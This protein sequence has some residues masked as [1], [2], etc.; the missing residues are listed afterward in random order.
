[1]IIRKM[2]LGDAS[3]IAE[4]ERLCFSDPWSEKSI[5]SEAEN[6]LSY[7]LVAEL[8]GKVVGYVGSQTVLDAA[9]MMNLAVSPDYRRQ[10]IGQALVNALVDHLKQNNV[11]ALLL[12]VR[13][14]N[15]QAIAL[16]EK[17]D[18]AQVGRRPKYYRNPRE[19]ALIL[20][21]ELMG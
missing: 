2:N 18:F 13:A 8:D 3:A 19:D 6:P 9:D 11:I 15:A 20:R 7:W 1:M 16:Y 5:A 10:G 12:E 17:L 4:L 21:K 14:S